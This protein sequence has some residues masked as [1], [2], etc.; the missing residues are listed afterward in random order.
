MD[1]VDPPGAFSSRSQQTKASYRI[2]VALMRWGLQNISCK[3]PTQQAL[4][5]PAVDTLTE[6]PKKNSRCVVCHCE[7]EADWQNLILFLDFFNGT[8][9]L[10]TKSRTIVRKL[11]LIVRCM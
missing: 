7:L 11:W 1:A 4:S 8:R 6:A 9:L 3:K 2:R 10:C 5:T